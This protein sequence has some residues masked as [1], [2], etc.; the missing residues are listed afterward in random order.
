MTIIYVITIF[1]I[2]V[3][4]LRAKPFCILIFIRLCHCRIISHLYNTSLLGFV[5]A[6]VLGVVVVAIV[7]VV[8]ASVVVG[9]VVAIVVVIVV[10]V[11]VVVG[12]VVAI[13]VVG[14]S[15]VIVAVVVKGT[16]VVVFVVVEDTVVV[17]AVIVVEAFDIMGAVVVVEI[18]HVFVAAGLV[19]V[20]VAWTFVVEFVEACAVEIACAVAVASFG[21]KLV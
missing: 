17:G 4:E 3:T 2:G 12:V 14:V 9:V 8:G 13:V 7:E 15:V 10:G 11:S 20:V 5:G 16:T 19:G 1:K 21:S 6:F 18:Y